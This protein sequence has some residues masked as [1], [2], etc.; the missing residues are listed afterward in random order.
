MLGLP[1]EALWDVITNTLN[2]QAGKD[3]RKRQVMRWLTV[4]HREYCRANGVHYGPRRGWP[5]VAPA[6]GAGPIPRTTEETNVVNQT[7]AAGKRPLQEASAKSKKGVKK[8]NKVSDMT[9]ALKEYTAM[10]KERFSSK[11]D[12]STGTSKQFGQSATGGDPCSLGKAIDMLN[13]YKDL[14]NKAY[15]KI[16]KAFHVKENRLVFI[17]MLKHRR[18]AWMDDIV[19]LED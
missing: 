19:N 4:L 12:K 2:A 3:F 1:H 14:G 7:Q 16:S 5:V 11:K 13:Q 18:R 15:L 9:M 17:G 10:T 6:E 8:V